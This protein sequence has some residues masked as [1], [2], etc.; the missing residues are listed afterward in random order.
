MKLHWDVAF[1]GLWDAI[2]EAFTSTPWA[3]VII[4]LLIV[5]AVIWAKDT[6]KTVVGSMIKLLFILVMLAI[7]YSI[8]AV[9]F[10]I[11]VG[12]TLAISAYCAFAG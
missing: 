7:L 12:I 1:A 5:I 11:L 4:V 10:Y 3:F 8:S 9:A 2:K 6:G